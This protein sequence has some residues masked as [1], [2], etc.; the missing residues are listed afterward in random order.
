MTLDGE[1]KGQRIKEKTEI[2]KREKTR[3]RD[4]LIFWEDKRKI[5]IEKRNGRLKREEGR[6]KQKKLNKIRIYLYMS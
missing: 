6:N 5:L 1:G 3:E 4:K 2:E